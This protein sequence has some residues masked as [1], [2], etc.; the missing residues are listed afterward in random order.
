MSKY[1]TQLGYIV[2]E[3]LS[4]LE[5]YEDGKVVC[6]IEN[7]TL[8]KYRD[9]NEDIDEESFTGFIALCCNSRPGIGMLLVSSLAIEDVTPSLTGDVNCDGEINIADVNA[10]IEMIL[11]DNLAPNGDI[12]N[13]GEITISDLNMLIDIILSY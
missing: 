2:R 1:Q 8:D 12:N 6:L 11:S 4:G 10:L 9:E 5:V 7:T 13:D 3:T